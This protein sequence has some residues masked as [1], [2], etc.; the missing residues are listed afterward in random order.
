MY[1]TISIFFFGFPHTFYFFCRQNW[2]PG[3]LRNM[4]QVSV[5]FLGNCYCLGAILLQRSPPSPYEPKKIKKYCPW[6]KY[7]S[8]SFLLLSRGFA[9]TL[10]F[11]HTHYTNVFI[12]IWYIHSYSRFEHIFKYILLIKYYYSVYYSYGV[13]T[14]LFCH[15][16][17]QFMIVLKDIEWS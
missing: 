4:K 13:S 2:A 5:L 8:L 7:S 12:S 11:I 14:S 3:N 10:L 16:I 6:L 9:L 1:S 15:I 17:I